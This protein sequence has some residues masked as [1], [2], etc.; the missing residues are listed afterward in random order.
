MRIQSNTYIIYCDIQF[1]ERVS[2]R[3]QCFHHCAY[4]DLKLSLSNKIKLKWNKHLREDEI[5]EGGQRKH[6]HCRRRHCWRICR[7][8][9]TANSQSNKIPLHWILLYL[10]DAK[11]T[12]IYRWKIH[13]NWNHDKRQKRKLYTNKLEKRNHKA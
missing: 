11:G 1:V 10:Q 13:Q 4:H 2:V 5:G 8:Q 7:Q 12:K 6:H 3:Q 9:K